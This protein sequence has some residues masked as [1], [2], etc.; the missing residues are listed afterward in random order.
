MPKLFTLSSQIDKP[1]FTIVCNNK[2][3]CF[4]FSQTK[5]FQIKLLAIFS[6]AEVNMSVTHRSLWCKGQVSIFLGYLHT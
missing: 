5:V 2:K 4:V 6:Q 1:G 3:I